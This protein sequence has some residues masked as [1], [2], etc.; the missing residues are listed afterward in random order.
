[1]AQ[2]TI[3]YL[4]DDLDGSDADETVQFSIDGKTYEIDLNKKN[5]AAMRRAFKRY[6]AKGR[7]AGRQPSGR[8]RGGG[9]ATLFSQ[10]DAEEKARF[11][12]WAKLPNARRIGDAR[13]KAWI[14]A[15]RP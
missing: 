15:G 11:R 12:K 10:L 4:T 3:T 6:I 1:M 5:A 13:V 14:S 7:S 9:G 8:R 2:S